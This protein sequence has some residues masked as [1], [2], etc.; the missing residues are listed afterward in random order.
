[1]IISKWFPEKENVLP[2]K[3]MTQP[4]RITEIADCGLS[5]RFDIRNIWLIVSFCFILFRMIIALD[6]GVAVMDGG[7]FS[8]L[9]ATGVLEWRRSSV[10]VVKVCWENRMMRHESLGNNL[11]TEHEP[12]GFSS[13]VIHKSE[14]N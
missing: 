12:V 11:M 6:Y 1:M 4:R 13:Y 10:P 7:L 8:P 5:W 3:V 9:W 14:F 2:K